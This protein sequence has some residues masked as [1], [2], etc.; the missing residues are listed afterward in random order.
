MLLDPARIKRGLAPHRAGRV[1]AQPGTV[2]LIVGDGL[3]DAACPLRAAAERRYEVG[4]DERRNV[5]PGAWTLTVPAGRASR[6]LAVA[7]DRPLDPGL[8]RSLSPRHG[9][10]G[11][12]VRRLPET[13]PQERSW[14][15]PPREPWVPGV[16]RLIVDPVL[17]D[18]AGNSV[19]RVFDRDLARAG[20]APQPVVPVAVPFRPR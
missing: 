13:R 20:D 4:A 1:S 19:S 17:E 3:R 2:P 8:L 5:D 15:L 18:L 11:P 14:R 9:P 7:F 16:H 6:P 10:G 12:P